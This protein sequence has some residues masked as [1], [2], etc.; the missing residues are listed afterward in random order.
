MEHQTCNPEIPCSRSTLTATVSRICFSV[1]VVL[2][3]NS[4]APLE[5]SPY[6]AIRDFQTCCVSFELF[7]LVICSPAAM[8]FVHAKRS[9]TRALKGP[10]SRPCNYYQSCRYSFLCAT[11]LLRIKWVTDLQTVLQKDGCVGF[12]HVFNNT[13][14][15]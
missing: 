11:S 8:A 5:N 14:P 9:L 10:D 15:Q 3:F 6:P 7:V 1:V 4:L 2:R 12:L 13:I